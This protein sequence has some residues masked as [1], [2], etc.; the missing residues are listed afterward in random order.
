MLVPFPSSV[1][2]RLLHYKHCIATSTSTCALSCPQA[3]HAA[4][5]YDTETLGRPLYG[6]LAV[7]AT[8][9]AN[10]HASNVFANN[11]AVIGTG[12]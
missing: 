2:I 9:V 11:V 7:S 12:L 1:G 8:N 6:P 4:A 10:F 3:I 5:F